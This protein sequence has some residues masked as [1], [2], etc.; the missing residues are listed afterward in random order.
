M[1]NIDNPFKKFHDIRKER[2]GAVAV[3][4]I[5]LRRFFVCVGFFCEE[6]WP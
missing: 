1:E 5:E 4:E 3:W 2:N 6:D